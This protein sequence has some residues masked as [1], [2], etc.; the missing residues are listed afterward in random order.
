MTKDEEQLNECNPYGGRHNLGGKSE[1]GESAE[2][3][4]FLGQKIVFGNSWD[5]L[6]SHFFLYKWWLLD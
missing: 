4:I 6:V 5:G 3:N 2:Q 1:T